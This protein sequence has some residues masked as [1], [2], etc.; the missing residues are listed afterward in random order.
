MGSFLLFLDH[1]IHLF[2]SGGAGSLLL[3]AAYPGR[4]A[5]APE[6]GGFPVEHR[7]SRGG[8]R[9]QLLCSL[10]GLPGSGVKSIDGTTDE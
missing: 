5:H 10:W 1:F 6:C 2:V 4:G 8:P 3:R 9:A 7:L